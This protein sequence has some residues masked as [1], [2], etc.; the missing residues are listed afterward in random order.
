MSRAD[1]KVGD[2]LKC[3]PRFSE[4]FIVREIIARERAGERIAI[5]SLRSRATPAFMPCLP[6]SRPPSSGSPPASARCPGR[7][8]PWL[9]YRARVLPRA[10][11]RSRDRP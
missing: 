5:A 8:T 6:T 11:G 3:Y 1:A 7:G 2:V 9:R 4:T 10:V